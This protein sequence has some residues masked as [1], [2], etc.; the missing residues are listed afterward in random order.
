MFIHPLPEVS[1]FIE[2]LNDSIQLYEPSQS[3]SRIQRLWLVYVLMGIIVTGQ[4]CWAAFERRDCFGFCSEA[5]L[6]WVFRCAKLPWHLLLQASLYLIFKRY[7]ISEGVLAIDDTSKERSKKTTQIFAAHKIKD[8]KTS[9][10]FNGQE[11]IFMVL[12]TPT[13][14]IPVDFCFY[15]PDPKQTTWRKAY[16][17][18]KQQG[19]A[20]KDRPLAPEK[21]PNYPKKQTLA[22]SMLKRFTLAFPHIIVKAVLADALYGCAEFMEQSR[23]IAGISQVISQLRGDQ[24]ILSKGRLISLRKYFQRQA[25]VEAEVQI[26]GGAIK[27]ITVLSAR[28][29]VKAHGKKRFVVAL[30]YE[31]ETE[32][33]FLVATNLSWRYI[34]IIR[35]YSLRWLIEVFIEDW[36]QHGGWNEMTKHQ[37][38]DGS[39]RGLILSL[40]CDHCLLFHPEQ[41][42]RLKNRKPGLPVGCLIERL[43]T[44][45]TIHTIKSVIEDDN[46]EEKFQKL[47][48]VMLSRLPIRTSKKHM[49]GLDL[50]RQD[51]TESL[52]YRAAA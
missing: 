22:V 20:R 18:A 15:Q 21:D 29:P 13:A 34:D 48:E 33:R 24:L 39:R 26:R 28:I 25:G 52:K 16:R 49:S 32:Y 6:R 37:G 23:A 31:G 38:E 5:K 51:I 47:S 36:K 1:E 35:T 4:L 42:A 19:V 8:K 43:R 7:R 40:L 2:K 3:L 11:L 12:V 9:G 14:T 44:E 50:G 41:S 46:P 45:A 30:K 17:Q 27:K 10:Y